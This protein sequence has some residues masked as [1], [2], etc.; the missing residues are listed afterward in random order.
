MH[1]ILSVIFV[2]V[3]ITLSAQAPE[4]GYE[5]F[6]GVLVKLHHADGSDDILLQEISTPIPSDYQGAADSIFCELGEG[7][8]VSAVFELGNDVGYTGYDASW[9][10]HEEIIYGTPVSEYLEVGHTSLGGDSYY[11]SWS[12]TDSAEFSVKLHMLGNPTHVVRLTKKAT[13]ALE[14]PATLQLAVF[15]NPFASN[16]YLQ[17]PGE[18]NASVL[19]TDAAG[20]EVRRIECSASQY[21]DLSDFPAGSYILSVSTSGE[22]SS[23]RIQKID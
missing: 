7:E 22:A 4:K 10:L 12:F 2:M 9:P 14:K 16:V 1:T 19:L 5:N 15:P 21:L 11:H 8:S 13:L 3:A 18:S 20:R 6:C 23:F 17:L